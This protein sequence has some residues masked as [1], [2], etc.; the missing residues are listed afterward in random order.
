[1][2]GHR[3]AA[4]L[5][6]ALQLVPHP[7]GGFYRETYRSPLRVGTS[8]GERAAVT[9]IHFLLPAGT[10]SVFHRVLAE[11]IWAHAGGDGLELHMLSPA[12]R[13]ELVRL[14]RDGESEQ[15]H[16]VVP[17]GY[18]QAARPMGLRYVLSTCVVAPGFEFSDFE[19]ARRSDLA[20]AFPTLPEEVLAL[21]AP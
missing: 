1:M 15:T 9:V 6:R 2:E 13:Y 21:A 4:S 3:D 19:L 14:G 11:E 10:V 12:G 16:A 20:G 17:A 5:V 8:R 18:W 7:E